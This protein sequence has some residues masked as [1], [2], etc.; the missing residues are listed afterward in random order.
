[1]LPGAYA[2]P[3]AVIFAVGGLLTCL[4]GYRLFRLVLLLYGFYAGALVT[5]SYM[6][7][8]GTWA[9]VIA[10]IVGGMVGAILMVAAYFM[11]V[12]LVGAGIAA[13]VLHV[14]WRW[15][16]TDPPTVLLVIVCVI[17]ALG[18]LSVSR[19]V[20]VFGTAIAG[21]WTLLVG[22]LALAGNT[23]A[24]AAAPAKDPWVV[25]PLDPLP[26][27]WWVTAAWIGLT[28]LG[29]IVQ[30]TTT[31]KLGKRKKKRAARES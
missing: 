21:A 26:K 7:P 15:F 27:A 10:A 13:L 20:V 24:M 14:I 11:G 22:G 18:A 6:D 4:A 28:L 3:A 29:V 25:Y 23:T 16:G 19:W 31:S 2:T 17:G 30:M 8:S 5:T 1:M 9:L 12:G